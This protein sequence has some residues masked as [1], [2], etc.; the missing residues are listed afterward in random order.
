MTLTTQLAPAT[1]KLLSQLQ[2]LSN[3]ELGI[4]SYFDKMY[5]TG[6]PRK[7]SYEMVM[8]A[9]RCK[10]MYSCE[11]WKGLYK[12]LVE[13]KNW[14]L[15][16]YG[17]FLKTVKT[18]GNFLIDLINK[19]VMYNYMEY[20]RRADKIAF[21]D[22]TPL[23]VC[24]TI[25]A[26]RHR[27]MKRL[28][29]FS[30]STTGWFLGLKLHLVCDYTTRKVINYSLTE[31]NYDDRRYLANVML[32][33]YFL[34]SGSLFVTDKGYLGPKLETLA[35]ETGNYFISGKKESKKQ[36]GL[37]SQFDIY[38]IHNR[39]K[40]ETLFSNLKLN[41]NLVSTRSRSKIGYFFNYIFSLFSLV[42]AMK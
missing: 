26:G 10:T 38:L 1:D 13:N 7:M 28:A 37:L 6:R 19:T 25:R 17:N 36:R 32:S 18:F 15:P 39:A 27:T 21:V 31:A 11:N 2:L 42:N 23:P 24:K 4:G 3:S 29:K 20:I 41:Y 16:C 30:K 8:E 9:F 14:Q 12:C 40:I 22:S 35:K 34:W 5:S 33:R